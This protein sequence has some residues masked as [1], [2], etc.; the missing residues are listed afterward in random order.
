MDEDGVSSPEMLLAWI[1]KRI[2]VISGMQHEL[3]Y[4]RVLLQEQATRLRLGVSP[5]EARVALRHGGL[6]LRQPW[7]SCETEARIDEAA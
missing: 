7:P 2:E 4:E 3:A 6:T 1:N 5:T